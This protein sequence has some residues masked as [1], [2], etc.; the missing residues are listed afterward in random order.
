MEKLS[1]KTETVD[2]KKRLDLY[3]VE[4]IGKDVSRT[5][6]Q[7]LIGKGNCLVNGNVARSNYRIR[8][9]EVVEFQ[10]E[11]QKPIDVSSED[12]PLKI[13]YE[14]DDL[15]IVD[16]PAGMV[17]HPGAGNYA[18]TLVNALL[19]HTQDL[20][21][22]TT[23]RPGI[24]HRLDK[25]TSG[26]MVV[27]KNDYIHRKIAKQFKNRTV[28]RKYVAIVKGDIGPDNG[29]VDAPIGRH[30][31]IREKMAV[32]YADSKEAVTKYTVIKRLG[33][34]TVVE[35]TP[36]TGRTH[37]LRIHMAHIGHPIVGDLSYGIKFDFPRQAL[38]AFSLGFVHPRTGKFVEFKSKMPKDME[39]F[40]HKAS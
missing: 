19:Y 4:K 9:N 28:I 30:P 13:I 39:K 18:G 15:L 34:F 3:L 25:D 31:R 16:K 20:S 26:V 33:K 7:D 8:G 11:E 12:I 14:D 40:I 38:H 29:I 1:F 37:Q 35:L 2:V 10:L 24:I 27:A 32:R 17:S 6:I 21:N 36:E 5:Y 22:K 23:V